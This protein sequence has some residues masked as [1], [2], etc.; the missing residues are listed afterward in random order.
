MMEMT[1][2]IDTGMKRS[3]VSY[4]EMQGGW[5]MKIKIEYTVAKIRKAHELHGIRSFWPA[6]NTG[7]MT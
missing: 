3:F 2:P 1:G 5:V 4:D 7:K 6:P